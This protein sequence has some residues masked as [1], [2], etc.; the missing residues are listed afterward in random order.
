MDYRELHAKAEDW[1]FEK[2]KAKGHKVLKEAAKNHEVVFDVY[3]AST[4]TAYEVLTAK[5]FR[6]AHE[7]DEMII[8]KIFHY[9][10]LVRRLRFYIVSYDR[11]ELELFHRLGLEHWHLSSEGL[12]NKK[13]GNLIY[14]RGKSALQIANKIFN[15]L[16]KFAPLEEWIKKGRRNAPGHKK[17][18]VARPFVALTKK[19]GLPKNFFIGLWRDWRLLWVW[20][21]E[22]LLPLWPRR[23][24][25]L[26][27]GIG[28]E[29]MAK[30]PKRE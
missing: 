16:V 24:E 12:F 15:A 20:R 25:I 3:D 28:P 21:L 4:D 19:L 30:I 18:D 5:F 26:K 27:K 10:L 13:V 29:L 11:Q 23:N 2:L 7:Q 1:I 22:Y 14:H 6:S 17:S 9:L 8:Y